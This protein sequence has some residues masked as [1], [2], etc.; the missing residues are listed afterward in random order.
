MDSCLLLA[1]AL[2][3]DA[4]IG[5]PPVIYRRVPHPVGLIGN[6]IAWLESPLQRY[7]HESNLKHRHRSLLPLLC[8]AVLVAVVLM[9]VTAIAIGLDALFSQ[10]TAGWWVE[11][12]VVSTLLAGRSL[13]DHVKAV[14]VALEQSLTDGRAA[15][16]H[17]VGRNT[18]QMDAGAVAR[19]AL[20]S[21]AENFSDGVVAPVFWY[22]VFGL[23]GICA[24]KAINTLD[25]MI[26]HR[27]PRYA[28]FGK[29]AARLDDLANW[30]PARI[31][32]LLLCTA[33]SLCPA[34]KAH[35]AVTT[36]WRY[37]NRHRSVNAGWPEA[38]V[39]GALDVSLSGPRCYDGRQ[40]DDPWI[41]T[42]PADL[43]SAH[44]YSALHLYI[45]ACTLLVVLLLLLGTSKN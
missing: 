27:S 20:E 35:R 18:Q 32:A 13:W 4:L 23:P 28:W 8:G 26:G 34:S 17:I 43:G 41:G 22:I 36:V 3:M 39:A 45:I 37:A 21:L 19:A 44:L 1:V 5:D 11:A 25:S 6:T 29:V 16:A 38:A 10:I 33:A 15:V 14:A 12:L 24:Y 9:L 30:L 31:S 7:C 40:T 42:G 2:M